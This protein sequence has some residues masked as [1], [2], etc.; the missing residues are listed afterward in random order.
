[1][2][3]LALRN[4]IVGF[5][6]VTAC[7]TGWRSAP[8]ASGLSVG[9]AD[10][11]PPRLVPDK[12]FS[13]NY[14]MPL[15]TVGVQ[16]NLLVT[17]AVTANGAMDTSS[18]RVVSA[19]NQAF[20]VGL[21]GS[22]ANLRFAPARKRG[23]PVGGALAIRIDF[24]LVNC[25]TTGGARRVTWAVDSDPPQVAIWQCYRPIMWFDPSWNMRGHA[26]LSGLYSEVGWEGGSSFILC[27][28]ESLSIAVPTP[29][30]RA[31][32]L[33]RREKLDW[34]PLRMLTPTSSEDKRHFVKWE[35]D[36]IGPLASAHLG[37][38]SSRFRPVRIL[39]AARWSDRSCPL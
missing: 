21:R 6:L 39:E 1:M 23:Q 11:T 27:R 37:I 35:G 31:V 22:L 26:T 25:D 9:R 18:V 2:V 3:K 38:E 29:S 36:I 15:R 7:A 33:D 28:G 13:P 5:V 4:C 17:F 8:I 19:T 20:T 10:G 30:G 14:P 24:G 16:G 12:R 32:P 34:T